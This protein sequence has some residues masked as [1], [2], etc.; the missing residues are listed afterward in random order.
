M[1]TRSDQSPS[2]WLTWMLQLVGDSFDGNIALNVIW[3]LSIFKVY[4]PIFHK[5]VTFLL[6]LVPAPELYVDSSS[7]S[8]CPTHPETTHLSIYSSFIDDRVAT[9]D[10]SDLE[11]L[12][13]H[14]YNKFRY[15]SSAFAHR[16]MD[17][18]MFAGYIENKNIEN[19]ENE[20]THD[21]GHMSGN[22]ERSQLTLKSIVA[23]KPIEGIKTEKSTIRR[24][25]RK[26]KSKKLQFSTGKGRRGSIV[27]KQQ[28]V[29]EF[30]D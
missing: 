4:L 18:K 27:H 14:G 6:V 10:I 30:E 23:G 11:R 26:S 29:G 22:F 16:N 7:A 13:Q 17:A 3:I 20:E 28:S 2:C 21:E 12:K 25:K 24:S 8:A 15:I 9:A 1:D 19:V 5:L